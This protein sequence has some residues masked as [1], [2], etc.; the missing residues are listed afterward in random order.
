MHCAGLK[1]EQESDK[2]F[3]TAVER[4][5][6]L[7]REQPE[8][9]NPALILGGTYNLRAM[10][11]RWFNKPAAALPWND[12]A[13]RALEALMAKGSPSAD[14]KRFVFSAH[15]ERAMTLIA[16]ARYAE[17]I[18][19]Y[20]RAIELVPDEKQFSWLLL[21]RAACQARQGDYARAMAEVDL[22]AGKQIRD[23]GVLYDLACV[24]SLAAEAADRDRQLSCYQRQARVGPYGQRAV[25]LLRQA[26][27]QGA[28]DTLEKRWALMNDDDLRPLRQRRDYC[29]FFYHLWLP[30]W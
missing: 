26:E 7:T 2:W 1:R 5:E 4:L 21:Q 6:A 17:A 25:E 9:V 16:L 10:T 18:T 15:G 20:D 24:A 30:Q 28:F 8:L 23:G 13:V 12:R 11:L 3:T 19:D 14:T 22:L 29:R 27:A